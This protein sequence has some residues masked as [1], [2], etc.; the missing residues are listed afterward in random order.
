MLKSKQKVSDQK[1]AK[2]SHSKARKLGESRLNILRKRGPVNAKDKQYLRSEHS[3]QR[4][5]LGGLS[6][7]CLNLQATKVFGKAKITAPTFY[8]HCSDT[9]D[10]LVRYERSLKNDLKGALLNTTNK[11]VAWT[12]LLA[13][14]DR[15]HD[16]FCATAKNRDFFLLSQLITGM[17]NIFDSNKN[18]SDRA[19]AVYTANAIAVIF[20]WVE[21][22]NHNMELSTFYVKKLLRLRFIDFNA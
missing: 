14:V 3:I 4:A 5:L 22:D 10:A 11:E 13:F 1:A 8:L 15:N 16:Y 21:Y 17:R 7:R 6:H 12:V 20:C 9:T 18:V 2:Q 19:Y